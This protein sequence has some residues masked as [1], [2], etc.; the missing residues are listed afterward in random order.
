MKTLDSFTQ[1]AN[2]LTTVLILTLLL[3]GA[4]FTSY[5]QSISVGPKLGVTNA[6]GAG[7][8]L[9]NDVEGINGFTGGIFIKY[10]TGNIFAFQPEILYV[11]KGGYWNEGANLNYELTIDY[12]EIPLL[13]KFQ[14]PVTDKLFPFVYAGPYGA[15]QLNNETQGQVFFVQTNGSADLKDF[16]AGLALGAGFDFEF[17]DFYFGFD[18]RYDIG[19]VNIFEE[20]S[21]GDQPDIKNR[22]LA[23]MIGLGVNLD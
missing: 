10:S 7:D 23:F 14:I 6:T 13:A 16:D 5:S 2:H 4:S 17:S 1:K 20:D 15:F 18:A 9:P 8:D 21:N 12:L 19:M 22:S 11:R 3:A